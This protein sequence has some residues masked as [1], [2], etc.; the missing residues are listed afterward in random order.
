[1][2]TELHG[3]SPG[4]SLTSLTNIFLSSALGLSMKATVPGC[5]MQGNLTV[6]RPVS[7]CSFD[8]L[9]SSDYQHSAA[10]TLVVKP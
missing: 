10:A 2:L 8:R 9:S 1:M 5:V 7:H 4:I 3:I 6:G